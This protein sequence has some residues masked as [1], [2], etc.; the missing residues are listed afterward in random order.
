M[1]DTFVIATVNPAPLKYAA[2]IACL[3][4]AGSVKSQN[5]DCA[6]AISV[7]NSSYDENDSPSGTGNVFEMAPGSCQSA[8]E[9]NSAWYV[10]SPQ[11]DGVLS[12]V[13]QPNDL[14]DDYDWSLFDITTG[15]CAGV[16]S[17]ASPELSCNSY[18]MLGGEQGP[19]GISTAMGGSGSSNGPGDLFGPPFNEDLNVTSG[20]IYALVVMNYSSTLNG[21]TLDFGDSNASIFDN[22]PPSITL[23]QP[24]CD[25]VGLTFSM[26]ENV[27]AELL[28]P[29]NI[30]LTYDGGTLNPSD[31]GPL[32]GYIDTMDF[33][34]PGL[35]NVIGDIVLHF[36]EPPTDLCGNPLADEYPFTLDGPVYMNTVIGPACNGSGGSISAE[37]GG[38]DDFCF[39]FFLNETEMDADCSSI[40]ITDLAPGTYLFQGIASIVSPY[41]GCGIS[42]NII[43]LDLSES[44]TIDAGPDTTLCSMSTPLNATVSGT[45]E[46]QWVNQPGLSIADVS[47]ATT[48]ISATTPGQYNIY[49]TASNEGCTVTDE[50]NIIFN[51]PPEIDLSTTNETCFHSCD[52]TVHILNIN[53]SSITA[54]LNAVTKTGHE[55]AFSDVCNG[56]YELVIIHGP[57]CVLSYPVSIQSPDAVVASFE[58]SAMEVAVADPQVTLTNAS[59]HAD[60]I[61]W[62]LSG[63]DMTSSEAVWQLTLPEAIG[64]YEIVLTASDTNG[65]SDQSRLLI[66]VRDDF[67]FHI[68]NSFTPNADGI[69][70]VFSPQFTF[71]PE[72]YEFRIFNRWGEK[73]FSST[74]Y[75]KVW[76]GEM[77]GGEYFCPDGVYTWQLETR[78]L[79][80]DEHTYSGHVTIVR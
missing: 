8:G 79:D 55:I 59:R 27:N 58:T 52:G 32:T 63:Y 21:Y 61:L 56:S 50:V 25:Q 33:G 10:F 54:T 43:I 40:S 41:Y 26:S 6:T 68:P 71:P 5:S 37:A 49:L 75:S 30:Y 18:G 29:A 39:D 67:Y 70:D 57:Q 64:F 4:L 12:F 2:L 13:L 53:P 60:S 31:F 35:E 34:V 16:N 45:S 19:T 11:S 3:I 42:S 65:C 15:G 48:N 73:V 20:A 22:D 77:L 9:F 17:G 28:N 74:D 72:T 44:I 76:T 23:C 69:N 24:S 14:A 1:G 51:Y 47:S 7:C 38:I 66:S 46:Y 80:I 36:V 62:Q 78:G